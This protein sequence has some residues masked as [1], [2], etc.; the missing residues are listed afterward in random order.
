MRGEE[1]A[2]Q[3]DAQQVAKIGRKMRFRYRIAF[4]KPPK[5]GLMK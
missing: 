1:T 2:A 4:L 5:V 3:F